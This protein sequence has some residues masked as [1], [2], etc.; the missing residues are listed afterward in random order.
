MRLALLLLAVPATL[1]AQSKADG[2]LCGHLGNPR[3]PTARTSAQQLAQSEAGRGAFFA[4][5]LAFVDGQ[6]GDAANAFQ[7]AVAADASNPVAHFYLGRAYGA[8]AQRANI[9]SKASLAKKTKHEFDRAVQL[10]PEYLDAR[11][12]LVEYY[13]QAP[14][15]LGGSKEKARAQIEEIR[16]RDTWW[17]GF[18]AARIAGRDRDWSTVIHEYDRLAAEYPDSLNAWASLAFGY[19]QQKRW[20][21]AWQTIERMQHAV[22]GS[23]LSHFVVGRLAAE[24]GQQLE[25]GEQSLK[26]YLAYTPQPGE[27]PLASAHWRLGTIYEERGRSDAAR[28]EYQTAVSLDPK[29]TGA[30]DALAKLK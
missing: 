20:D 2:T 23:M 30:R 16:R 18:V 17:G 9:F 10:D 13:T 28:A 27:P 29:L 25:R 4:G 14:G 24:S 8:Q 22:P 5:C 1:A 11:E 19:A 7:R 12:G 3:F 21:D 26:R 6:Y 15:I